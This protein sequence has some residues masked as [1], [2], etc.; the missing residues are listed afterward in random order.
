MPA[1]FQV[2]CG[3]MVGENRRKLKPLVP[4]PPPLP[5]HTLSTSPSP[6]Q[7]SKREYEYIEQIE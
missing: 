7:F 4:P 3:S 5:P 6:P 2:I 1:D